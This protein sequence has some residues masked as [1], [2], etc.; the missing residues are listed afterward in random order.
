MVHTL[1]ISICPSKSS[2]HTFL[3]NKYFNFQVQ[4]A[5]LPVPVQ[6]LPEVSKARAEHLAAFEVIRARDAHAQIQAAVISPIPFSSNTGG[7]IPVTVPV[8]N[9]NY[10]SIPYANHG[11]PTAYVP[12][13]QYQFQDGYGQY[14]YG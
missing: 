5:P 9:V 11:A 8:S 13:S 6:D 12:M 3:T 7:T 2:Q 10:A 14:S 4:L 1:E